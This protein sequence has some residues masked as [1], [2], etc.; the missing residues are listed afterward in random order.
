M[1][2]NDEGSTVCIVL[3][4]MPD[5]QQKRHLLIVRPSYLVVDLLDDIKRQYQYDAFDL[6]LKITKDAEPIVLNK[7][8]G[9]TLLEVG[10]K[11]TSKD[12]N[13]LMID[14]PGQQTQTSDTEQSIVKKKKKPEAMNLT[15]LNNNTT[16][17]TASSVTTNMNGDSEKMAGETQETTTNNTTNNT[18]NDDSS[19][20]N[21]NDMGL[22]YDFDLELGA[23]ASPT[24]SLG[25]IPYPPPNPPALPMYET[26]ESSNNTEKNDEGSYGQLRKMKSLGEYSIIPCYGHYIT[27][28]FLSLKIVL[29]S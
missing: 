28:L 7:H 15:G 14:K 19:K 2:S 24:D 5:S 22:D 18:P 21:V 23:S 26:A 4:H 1:V 9:K 10:L 3:D 20:K 29:I 25:S 6:K 12:R 27:V 11:F 13:I 16:N 8:K 17:G